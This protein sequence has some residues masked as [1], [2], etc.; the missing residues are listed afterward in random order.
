MLNRTAAMASNGSK[1]YQTQLIR[2][3]GFAVPETLITNDPDLV[4]AFHQQHRRVIYKSISGARSIV[5][6]L[7]ERISSGSTAFGGVRRSS[8]PCG[9]HQ[10]AVAHHRHKGVC[11]G[12]SHPGH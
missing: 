4:R 7:E 2:A 10:R 3:H 5:H 12:H 9:G 11:H 1:P 6:T 8:R